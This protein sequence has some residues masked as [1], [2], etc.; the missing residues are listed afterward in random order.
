MKTL[1]VESLLP[2][3]SCNAMPGKM[4]SSFWG[5]KAGDLQDQHRNKSQN[6]I[7]QDDAQPE[8]LS[9]TRKA[10]IFNIPVS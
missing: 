6:N 5:T 1:F 8:P 3:F 2:A 9:V 10:P 4:L 7:Q